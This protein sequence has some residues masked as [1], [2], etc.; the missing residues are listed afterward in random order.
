MFEALQQAAQ[1]CGNPK[2][3]RAATAIRV[4]R[5]RWPYTNPAAVLRERLDLPGA[6]T[7]ISQYG[8]NFVQTV[9]NQSALDIQ[10]GTHDVILITGAECGYTQAKAKRAGEKL[11]WEAL[12]G[13]P[14]KVYGEDIAMS[15][16]E[17]LKCQIGIPIQFYAM[18]ENAPVPRSKRQRPRGARASHAAGCRAV[19]EF[20]RRGRQQPARLDERAENG[21]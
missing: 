3:I 5:G 19:V 7:A 2:I 6:E 20:Q 8:G 13:A 14:D 18:F 4:V 12:G 15:H 9:V 17:E 16:P 1:D 11:R 21:G 10:A